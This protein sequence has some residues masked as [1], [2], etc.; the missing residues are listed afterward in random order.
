MATFPSYAHVQ[1]RGAGESPSPVVLR[2][3]MERGVAKQRRFAADSVV[4]VGVAILFRSAADAAS[5]EDWFY[6]E[7]AGG[8]DWF[9]WVNPRGGA[10]VEARIVDGNIG[11]LQPLSGAWAYAERELVLEY[12]RS[13][14]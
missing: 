4:K 12:V 1:L 8:A 13:A 5:F 9:D 7:I 3:E 11:T 14:M 10:T 2:S 6:D